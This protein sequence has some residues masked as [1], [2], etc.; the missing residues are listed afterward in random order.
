M[1]LPHDLANVLGHE[2]RTL[3]CKYTPM[4][5]AKWFTA[6]I[7]CG[8]GLIGE[9]MNASV[10]RLTDDVFSYATEYDYDLRH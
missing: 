2:Q 9:A 3:V 5:T 7:Q 4:T 8:C 1:K 6:I 10:M